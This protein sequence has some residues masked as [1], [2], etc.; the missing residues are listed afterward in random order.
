MI[1]LRGVA[2]AALFLFDFVKKLHLDNCFVC[3]KKIDNIATL[4]IEHKEPWLH[5]DN[6]IEL[7]FSLGNIAFSH[8]AC[9][10][11]KEGKGRYSYK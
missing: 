10:R 2:A 6:P 3:G 8:R 5:S 7:F 9:S 1:F 4:S 11:A